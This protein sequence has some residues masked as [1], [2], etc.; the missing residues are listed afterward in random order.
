MYFLFSYSVVD[1]LGGFREIEVCFAVFTLY[2]V[3]VL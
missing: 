3:F 2:N 1:I